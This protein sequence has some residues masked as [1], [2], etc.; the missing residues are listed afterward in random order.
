MTGPTPKTILLALELTDADAPLLAAGRTYA[1]AFGA[2][3]YVVHVVPPEPDFVGLPR[4]GEGGRPPEP[5]EPRV[6]YA[7]DRT[8]KATRARAAH[9]R[10]ESIRGEL[11]AGGIE[12]TAL[13]IE[14]AHGE[15]I[16][17]EAA[18]LDAGLII[19]GSHQRSTLGEWLLGST[20]R[21]VLRATPCPV[22]VVPI[23]AQ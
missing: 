4:E 13:L 8:M 22:L 10:L 20:S 14:G 3:L 7:Y 11:E 15:K 2:H 17:D 21:A 12:A 5:G 1:R 18:R 6:G 19:V 16:L 9:E 23:Q